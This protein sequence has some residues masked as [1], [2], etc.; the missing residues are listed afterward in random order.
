MARARDAPAEQRDEARFAQIANTSA[1]AVH[2]FSEV[3][4][5]HRPVLMCAFTA[6][7]FGAL[8]AGAQDQPGRITGAVSVDPSSDPL[9]GARVMIPGTR[10]G[11]VTRD[12]GRF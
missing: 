1:A 4:M 9:I 8:P 10:I 3:G 7:S 12:E 6:L 2:T 5:M 11:A